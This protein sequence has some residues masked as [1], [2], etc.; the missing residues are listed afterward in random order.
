MPPSHF[1]SSA[2]HGARGP[3]EGA[4]ACQDAPGHRRPCK[5]NVS[6]NLRSGVNNI[7]KL[8]SLKFGLFKTKTGLFHPELLSYFTP[9]VSLAVKKNLEQMQLM[10]IRI[11][12]SPSPTAHSV[13][14]KNSTLTVLVRVIGHWVQGGFN[15]LAINR[16]VEKSLNAVAWFS[17]RELVG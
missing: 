9:L 14:H 13:F 4:R 7:G 11:G 3:K 16:D 5:T 10:T 12:A 17:L 8:K 1:A 6:E 2:H 15:L